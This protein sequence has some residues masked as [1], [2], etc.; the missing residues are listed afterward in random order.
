LSDKLPKFT[1]VDNYF[2]DHV[3]PRVK[4]AEWKVICAVLRQTE[5]F[6]REDAEI[7][8]E[9]F[10]SMTGHERQTVIVAVRNV[11]LR[12]AME[13]RAQQVGRQRTFRFRA[14]P[15]ANL[16]ELPEPGPEQLQSTL[17]FNV[18]RL[19]ESNNHTPMTP[20][21]TVENASQNR[22]WESNNWTPSASSP[23]NRFKDLDLK[24]EFD[25]TELA[26]A[27]EISICRFCGS[28]HEDPTDSP[29]V[30]LY[31]KQFELMPNEGFRHDIWL[32]VQDLLLWTSILHGWWYRNLKGRR[33]NKN[34][35]AIKQMLAT[36]EYAIERRRSNQGGQA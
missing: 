16:K 32:T 20:S 1:K 13:R 9:E 23:I 14:V 12:G 2:L 4:G 17:P 30:A 33:I 29:A 18:S 15:K 6:Q 5:G 7:S 21:D 34:P 25:K 27:V 36:Y 10:M 3:M 26:N 35:L 22:T 8:V 28:C 11:M 24:N 19:T 31:R